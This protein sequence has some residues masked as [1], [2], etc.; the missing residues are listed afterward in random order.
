MSADLG[1]EMLDRGWAVFDL[2]DRAIVGRARDRLL[3]WSR[4]LL[5]SD[6]ERLEHYHAAIDDDDRHLAVWYELATRFWAA[7]LGIEIVRRNLE[8]IQRL[9]GPDLHVQSYPYLRVARPG[10]A[11]DC[12]G[13]HRDTYYG[14]SP[15]EISLFIP[16]TELTA[17][18]ALRV[19]SGSH[20][21][22]D[23]AYPF[24]QQRRA[25]VEVGSKAHRLGFPYAPRTLDPAVA[26]RAEP[27]PVD[28]G[29]ALVFSLSLVHGAVENGSATTRVSTDVRVVNSFAPV[30]WQRG[31]RQDYYRPLCSSPVSTQARRYLET[32]NPSES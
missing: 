31:V 6:L 18:S 7:E 22:P 14:A 15:Y 19:V 13:W 11:Q 17:A 3:R 2:P 30:Q 27:V 20:V 32:R 24:T 21:E 26:N 12:V 4:E 1:A 25:D 8:P 29:Q 9:L 23:A 16:F 28:I 5:G 10:R